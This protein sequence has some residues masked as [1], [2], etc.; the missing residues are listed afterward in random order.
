MIDIA[1]IANVANNAHILSLN[2]PLNAACTINV[3]ITDILEVNE[4]YRYL[5]K[6]RRPAPSIGTSLQTM[7]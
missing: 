3:I 2:L 1:S 5:S 7:N 6:R 4:I